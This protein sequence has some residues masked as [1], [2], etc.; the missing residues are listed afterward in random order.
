MKTTK[1]LS[2]RLFTQREEAFEHVAYEEEYKLYFAVATGNLDFVKHTA[3]SYM[4]PTATSHEQNGILSKNPLQNA[5]FHAV[6]F[7]TLITR[8]CVEH[9]MPREEAY[10]LSD[11]YIN[12]IDLCKTQKDIL[13][14]Q[15]ESILDYTQRMAMLEKENVYAL[16][17]LH[18]I[19]YI[20]QHLQ[21]EL[22]LIT[23][24]DKLHLSPSYLSFLFKK[25][26]GRN[27]KEYI[28]QKK[29]KAAADL[30]LHSDMGYADIAEYFHFSSQ[31]YFI[32]CFK[33]ATGQTPK[34]YRQSHYHGAE[35]NRDTI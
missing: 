3:A 32:A 5:K 35:K 24:A 11:L 16:P 26:T 15:G 18:A 10:T 2:H 30:L 12:R 6:I 31:S 27:I 7:I 23:I 29:V 1:E 22:T 17:I 8:L 20:N 21:E 9:G 33:K 14:I 4:S 13:Y 25:E 34:Q 19:E 28:L